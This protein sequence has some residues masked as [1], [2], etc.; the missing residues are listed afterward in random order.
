MLGWNFTESVLNPPNCVEI[1]PWSA[2]VRISLYFIYISIREG[3][4]KKKNEK[5]KR[6]DKK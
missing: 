1:V 2:L 4:K 6:K 5:K 3:K